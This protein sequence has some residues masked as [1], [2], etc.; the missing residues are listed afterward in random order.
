[1]QGQGPSEAEKRDLVQRIVRSPLFSNSQALQAFLLFITKHA[2]SGDTQNIKEQRI[3]C[4]VLGRRPDYDPAAD[5]IVRVR[6]HEL[7]QKL[8]RHFATAGSHEPI[9]ITI[10]KGSY[11][12]LFQARTAAA[13]QQ[14]S[15]VEPCGGDSYVPKC[16]SW[17]DAQW[18]AVRDLWGQF[19]P[20]QGEELTV[21]AS[22]AAFA[23]WQD[24][25]G[26]NLTLG[27]YLSR[28]YLDMGEPTL[29]EV[30]VRRCVAPADLVI[31]LRM[32]DVGEAFGGHLKAHYAR[33]IGMADLRSGSAVI[34]GSRRSNP[35]V[36]LFE[37]R[38][39]FVLAVG[40]PCGGP[41]FENRCPRPGEP[42][43]FAI[44]CR[45]DIDGTERTEMESY[46]LIALLP[47]LSDMGHVLVLEGLNME[48]TEAAGE[49]VTN[50]ERLAN[51]LRQI[52]HAPGSPVLPFEALLRL[53]SIPGGYANANVIAFRN[54]LTSPGE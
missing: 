16:V 40:S 19:F 43:S 52:G 14:R 5:N 51:L 38:L 15:E 23:L 45:F 33:S 7:R 26:Q 50:P 8:A 48:G 4:E 49:T 29:R 11:V 2:I 17:T 53:T 47:N 36:Q 39:N 3:G 27:D 54:P 42:D 31:S 37:A 34:L 10:P 20:K 18:Q 24:I 35:W 6:A 30:A 9:V 21:V 22:D 44:P 1:M 32:V 46:A 28:K 12:P 13:A 25:T 41:R